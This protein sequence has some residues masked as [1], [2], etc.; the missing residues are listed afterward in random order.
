VGNIVWED[1]T[2]NLGVVGLINAMRYK[3]K[4]SRP[5]AFQ[6][7]ASFLRGRVNIYTYSL[8]RGFLSTDELPQELQESIIRMG[9]TVS[10]EYSYSPE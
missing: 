1:V 2:Y 3:I 6:Q 7:V 5:E 10:P 8:G 4:V 9:A